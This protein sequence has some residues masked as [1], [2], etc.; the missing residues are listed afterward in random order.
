L[1]TS[2][3][4]NNPWLLIPA[5]DYEEH[6][7]CPEVQQLQY[8]S[9]VFRE[10]L[11]EYKPKK[12]AVV[13]CTTGNGFE[14][15]DFDYV[16]KLTGID[17][18][19]DYLEILKSRF[20]NHADKLELIE[21]DVCNCEFPDNSI[22]LIHCALVLEYLDPDKFINL[23]SKWINTNGVFTILLQMKSSAD[24]VTPTK[25]SSLR[26]LEP[27]MKLIPPDMILNIA[28]KHGLM[29]IKQRV[30]TLASGK[31]FFLATFRKINNF[32]S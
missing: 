16:D 15:V 4:K 1:N 18:N 9:E 25:F 24:K 12:L 27:V 10:T 17:V 19:P 28:I 3:V 11:A 5:T 26:N 21:G 7:R 14:H 29:P 23:A 8:L 22:E 6:M 31:F 30:D 20:A 13:G 32:I 2:H